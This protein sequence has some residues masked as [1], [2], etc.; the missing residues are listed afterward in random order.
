MMPEIAIIDLGSQFTQL[1]ARKLRENGCC[2]CI[3]NPSGFTFS[4]DIKGVILSGSHQST[5]EYANYRD[6]IAMVLSLNSTHGIPVLGICYG[7][8]LLSDF[9]GASVVSG[10]NREYGRARLQIVAESP[11]VSNI[12]AS[13]FTVWMSHGDAVVTLP[14]GFKCVA[15]TDDCQFA[16]IADENRKI[17]G[18]Q[19]HPEVSH[20]ENGG[21]LLRNFISIA[22]VEN[23]WDLQV[24]SEE[25]KRMVVATTGDAGVL[26]AVSGGVDST[27]AAK[28]MHGAI[29]ERLHCIFVDTGLLR[30]NEANEVKESFSS[31]GI[32]LKIVFA[33]DRFFKKLA[34]VADPEQKRRIVGETFIQ[35]FEEE[36]LKIQGVEF[37]L[38]GTL[39]PDVIESGGGGS[40]TIKS[41]HNVGG[42]PKK[43]GLKLLEPFRL[44]FKDEV[45]AIG[46]QLGVSEVLLMRHPS[47]GPALAIRILGEV[48]QEKVAVLQD[49]DEIYISTMKE[50]NL[51]SHIWQA[52]SVLLPV[53][54]VGVMGD[55]RSYNYVCALR[56]I[57]SHDGM[58][59][60]AYPF[61]AH[62]DDKLRFLSF[63]NE[64]ATKIPNRVSA[65]SRVV[66]DIT[67]KPP[68][69]V[70]W[71]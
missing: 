2:S 67:S 33:A 28:F 15:K 55:K 7:K 11:I 38:Q 12:S 24:F 23:T 57:V 32:P 68:A 52:F 43:M 66:Y 65:V 60:S 48:T 50:Y 56:A 45:R 47:P 21:V 17:Y 13:D 49:I 3:Y 37:L 31:L 14:C 63:L 59:A 54:S 51:Y 26:A 36:A 4:N 58:T 30:K 42:L 34:G 5:S 53:C 10:K 20:T 8:Q 35:V 62:D 70:E 25:E 61:E 69:T 16:L 71:E 6:L 27:V 44:L 29:G 41:H 22:G 64:V 9:L 19:F 40:H 39:Y 18:F 46:R 1:I